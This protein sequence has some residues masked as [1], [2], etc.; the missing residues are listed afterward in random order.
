LAT[1]TNPEIMLLDEIT[2]GLDPI[3]R[4]DLYAYIS[5]KSNCPHALIIS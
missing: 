2:C 4:R 1:F 5:S 3:S